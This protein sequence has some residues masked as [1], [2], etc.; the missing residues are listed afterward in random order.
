METSS[1]LQSVKSKMKIE[2]S[3]QI[4]AMFLLAFLPTYFGFTKQLTLVYYFFYSIMFIFTLYYFCQ[5][6]AFYK[7][8][9]TINIQNIQDARWFYHELRLEL[10]NYKSFHYI[11]TFI[12]SGFG[13]LYCYFNKISILPV[14]NEIAGF[15]SGS[16]NLFIGSLFLVLILFILTESVIHWSYHKE[17]KDLKTYIAA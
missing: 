3:V 16:K 17:L 12:A 10:T 9:S 15:F 5:F 14:L 8:C 4:L 2:F 13:I 6:Y 1:I 11:T 7:K